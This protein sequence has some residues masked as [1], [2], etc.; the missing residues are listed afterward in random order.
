MKD[1]LLTQSLDNNIPNALL[2]ILLS[3]E[4]FMYLYNLCYFPN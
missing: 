4:I 1:D 3:L 2:L